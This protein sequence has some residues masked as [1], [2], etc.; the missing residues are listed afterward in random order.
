MSRLIHT[1]TLSI[2]VLGLFMSLWVLGSCGSVELSHLQPFAS[3]H[4][5]CAVVPMAPEHIQAWQNMLLTFVISGAAAA[6]T[7]IFVA[8]VRGI[9]RD[10]QQKR[11]HALAYLPQLAEQTPHM[12]FW[13][14]L[15]EAFAHGTIQHGSRN[16]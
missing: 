14:P 9:V 11:L 16:A 8:V 3:F 15:R 12:K 2:F 10:R 4:T 7:S 13:D 5:T 1:A 6:I